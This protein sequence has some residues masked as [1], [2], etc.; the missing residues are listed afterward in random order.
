MDVVRYFT[1]LEIMTSLQPKIGLKRY[2]KYNNFS[3]V[4]VISIF[5]T[6]F[7]TNVPIKIYR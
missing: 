5:M 6:D 4:L 7:G 3:L 2:K 1:L